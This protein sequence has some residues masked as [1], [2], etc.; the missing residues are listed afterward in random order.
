M[1]KSTL[2]QITNIVDWYN[3]LPKG[4]SEVGKLQ[5]AIRKMATLIFYFATDVGVAYGE[6]NQ[7]AFGRKASQSREEDFLMK[8]GKSGTA[9]EKIAKKNVESLLDLEQQT[10]SIYKK[11]YFMLEAAKGV[12]EAMRQHIS[13]LKQERSLELRG[14]MDNQR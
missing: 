5:D 3:K 1:E 14:G 6:S 10:D 12:M 13:N 7:K 8:E 2:E 11:S 4:F 9:A